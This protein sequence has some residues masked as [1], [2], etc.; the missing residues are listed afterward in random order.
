MQGIGS[1]KAYVVEA[2]D[3]DLN[4]SGGL[5]F[6]VSYED[7]PFLALAVAAGFWASCKEQ[8]EEIPM[9]EQST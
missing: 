3:I 9:K 2:E 1:G 6:W 7:E 8:I 4:E 5:E